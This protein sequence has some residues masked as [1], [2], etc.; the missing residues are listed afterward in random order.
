MT[1]LQESPRV[2]L[3]QVGGLVGPSHGGEG[4]QAAAEP[5]VQHI[6]ILQTPIQ[7]YSCTTLDKHSLLLCSEP[8]C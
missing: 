5:G 6:L 1:S 2:E 7:N 4:P 3:R 8:C